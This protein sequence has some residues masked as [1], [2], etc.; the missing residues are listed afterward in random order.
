M[1]LTVNTDTNIY[2]S[3]AVALLIKLF[4]VKMMVG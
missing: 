4:Q 1:V 2:P 3:P